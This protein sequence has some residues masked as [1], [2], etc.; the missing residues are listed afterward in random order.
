MEDNRKVGNNIL[1]SVPDHQDADG[2]ITMV[3]GDLHE[4]L[5]FFREQKTTEEKLQEE[6]K[7][8]K[9]ELTNT[10]R[11]LFARFDKLLLKVTALEEFVEEQKRKEKAINEP[12]E[13]KVL[14]F[15]LQDGRGIQNGG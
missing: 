9:K 14:E 8:T 4:Q 3:A 15:T 13:R 5:D 1:I 12:H 7:E 6:L 10:R 2:H 11:G